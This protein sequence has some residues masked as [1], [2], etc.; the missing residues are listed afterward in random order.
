MK[1][2]LLHISK[3]LAALTAATSRTTGPAC[4][5]TRTCAVSSLPQGGV[6]SNLPVR[7]HGAGRL[8]ESFPRQG[9]KAQLSI[10]GTEYLRAPSLRSVPLPRAMQPAPARLAGQLQGL[11]PKPMHQLTQERLNS[12]RAPDDDPAALAARPHSRNRQATGTATALLQAEMRLPGIYTMLA[13]PAAR[14]R[15]GH[16]QEAL[17][18]ALAE[19]KARPRE[20][21][22]DFREIVARELPGLLQKT[23]FDAGIYA[24]RNSEVGGYGR[25]LLHSDPDPKERFCLQIFAFDPRQKTPIHNHPNECASY[26]AQG[27]LMERVYELPQDAADAGHAGQVAKLQKN[28]RPQAS[29]AGFDLTQ[30]QVPHSLKNKSDSLAVSV[31]LYRDM[32]GVSEGQQVAAADKFE[33][34][35]P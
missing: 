24:A 34:F 33:R 18:H 32:D 25:Y 22:L 11:Q 16:H 8:N 21:G 17:A 4:A 14:E 29:W 3:G 20:D 31:H 30:L 10:P 26:I 7:Q 6:L 9:G 2:T 23:G 28:E 5:A 15:H 35:K 13:A 27:V 12:T 1:S 19:L